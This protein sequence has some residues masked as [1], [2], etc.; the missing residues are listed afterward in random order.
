M[1]RLFFTLIAGLSSIIITFAQP[2]NVFWQRV[3]YIFS[4]GLFPPLRVYPSCHK[5]Q[6]N[7]DRNYVYGHLPQEPAFTDFMHK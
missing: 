3:R 5:Q 1:K 7:P 6:R 2:I 4:N